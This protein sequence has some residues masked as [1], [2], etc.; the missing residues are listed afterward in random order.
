[1]LLKIVLATA[2]VV[3]ALALVKDGR[4]LERSGLVGRCTVV[5]TAAADD[6]SVHACRPGKLEGRPDLSRD[7]CTSTGVVND[8]EY[9][10]CPAAVEQSPIRG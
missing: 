7:S 5:Q 10:R 3:A 9:W 1:M 8:V 6:S 4:V 2:A